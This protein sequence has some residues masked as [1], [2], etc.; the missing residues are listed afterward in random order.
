M[1]TGWLTVV[2]VRAALAHHASVLGTIAA[3]L[4]PRE[5]SLE[6]NGHTLLVGNFGDGAINVY[7]PTTGA[8]VGTLLDTTG[9]TLVI[10]GLWALQF[11]NGGS[12]GT[13]GVLYFTS[14]P[15]GE[16]HGLF[17]SLQPN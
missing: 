15:D 7:N 5:M 3:G 1:L 4:F 11:G 2:D 9:N 16:N 14:G 8:Y 17:G 12:G 6:P 10:P 13:I